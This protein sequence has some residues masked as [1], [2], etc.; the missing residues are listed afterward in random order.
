MSWWLCKNKQSFFF[1]K[2]HSDKKRKADT[3]WVKE[4]KLKTPGR[5][6]E[7][8][9]F[10]DMRS[11]KTACCDH[12]QGREPPTAQVLRGKGGLHVN[13]SRKKL[14]WDINTPWKYF[15]IN[16]KKSIQQW[17]TI[18]K[19]IFHWAPYFKTIFKLLMHIKF[20]SI[21]KD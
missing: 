9:A 19:K 11:P 18:Y 13:I 21:S 10:K 8:G 1:N 3:V 20:Y 4:M 7:V 16:L 12:S 6:L 15:I 2:R 5:N 14:C 17:N